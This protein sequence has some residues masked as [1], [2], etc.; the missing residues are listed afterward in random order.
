MAATRS[1]PDPLTTCWEAAAR[2]ADAVA[3]GDRLPE[4]SSPV[5]LEPGETLH[6]GVDLDGWRHQG[7]DVPYEQHRGFVAG[8]LL[9][10]GVTAAATV[11]ANRRARL[12][13]ERLAAPQWRALGHVPVLATSHRLIVF[14]E[15]S[16]ASVWYE[17]ICQIRPAL[18]EGRLELIFEDDPAYALQGQWVPYLAVVLATVLAERFGVDAVASAL[19]AV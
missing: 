18:G 11:A 8:G 19:V 12:E 10:S 15:G 2:L 14:H 4:L 5:S 6:A 13:A 9:M 7:L 16:W 3:S 1:R 17:A